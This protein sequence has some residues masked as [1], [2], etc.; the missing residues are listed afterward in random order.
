MNRAS[1]IEWILE[2]FWPVLIQYMEDEKDFYIQ[3][4]GNEMIGYINCLKEH[5]ITPSDEDIRDMIIYLESIEG[6]E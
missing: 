5:D 6:D 1:K 2:T 3:Q 4:S